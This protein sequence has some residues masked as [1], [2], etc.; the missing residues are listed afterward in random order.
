MRA[1]NRVTWTET[2]VMGF[3]VFFAV[4]AGAMVVYLVYSL[5]AVQSDLRKRMEDA[6]IAISQ[7]QSSRRVPAA[8]PIPVKSLLETPASTPKPV[9]VSGGRWG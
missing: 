5:S 7:L 9:L 3:I 6:E 2:M 4:I 1:Q 8:P